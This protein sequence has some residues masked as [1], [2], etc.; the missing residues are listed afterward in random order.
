MTQAEWYTRE[1]A[2]TS[3]EYGQVPEHRS[4]EDLLKKGLFIVDKPFGPTSK[5][6]STWI[7]EELNLKKTGHF[8]TLD[9]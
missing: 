9:P 4:I 3:E 2:E 5:Q 1:E 8:G 7:K 6:V